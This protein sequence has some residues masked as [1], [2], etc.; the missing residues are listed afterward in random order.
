M[1]SLD[2]IYDMAEKLEKENI[3]Y[4]IMTLNE[5]KKSD[6]VDV[7]YKIENEKSKQSFMPILEQLG[8]DL[9]S[10]DDTGFSDNDEDF[11]DQEPD[12]ENIF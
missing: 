7:F 11:F 4:I 2:F 6:R 9:C 5:G 12:D 3:S 10:E 8:N 1:P